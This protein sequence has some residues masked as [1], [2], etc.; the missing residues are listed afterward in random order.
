MLPWG[1]RSSSIPYAF[2]RVQGL[3]EKCIDALSLCMSSL[4]S[5]YNESKL[6][7]LNL[8]P[9]SSSIDCEKVE[10][11]PAPPPVKSLLGPTKTGCLPLN[12][13]HGRP[14][15]K[16]QYSTKGGRLIQ[17]TK[18]RSLTSDNDGETSLKSQFHFPWKWLWFYSI[19]LGVTAFIWLLAS[20]GGDGWWW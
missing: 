7:R 14:S 12:G 8:I 2:N 1:C 17:Q 15:S 6:Q 20:C 10:E 11:L 9:G 18:K 16:N 3:P 13:N 5:L 19:L 4:T